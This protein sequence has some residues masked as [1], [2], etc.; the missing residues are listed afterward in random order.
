VFNVFEQYVPKS[1]LNPTRSTDLFE[2]AMEDLYERGKRDV[3]RWVGIG[4]VA[5]AGFFLLNYLWSVAMA[6]IWSG[7]VY[8]VTA[9]QPMPDPSYYYCPPPW[10]Q[11]AALTPQLFPAV[12]LGA[13]GFHMIG[14]AK[15]E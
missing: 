1:R 5:V 3:L 2:R 15:S 4:L 10:E 13:L 11:M 8:G 12:I 6:L 7:C 14:E 9:D